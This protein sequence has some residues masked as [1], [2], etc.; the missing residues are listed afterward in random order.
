MTLS[1]HLP[2]LWVT[3]TLGDVLTRSVER[4]D[5]HRRPD[6]H[7]FYLG[8]EHV[9]SNSGHLVDAK[10]VKG[11]TIQSAKTVFH[12]N[13]ILYGKLRP[14][15]NK[16][17]LA[18]RDGIA[19]TD[20]WVLEPSPAV[21]PTYAASYLRSGFVLSRATQL[22]TGANLPR[23]H[24]E[25]FDAIPIPLPPLPEQQRIAVILHEVEA[26]T[27][28]RAHANALLE[29]L[30]AAVF[31]GMFGSGAASARHPSRVKMG[32]LLAAPLSHGF[33]PSET[34]SRT[35]VP[36]FTLDAITDHGIAH[37]AVKF[38]AFQDY[39]GNG[40]DLEVDDILITRSN[41]I[42]LVGKAARY[43]G[44]PSPVIYPDLTIRIRLKDPTDSPYVE[45]YLRSP[46]MRAVIRRLARGTSG[47][48]KKISQGDIEQ[49]DILWPD[50]Q[51][52]DTFARR[53]LAVRL[54]LERSRYG[55]TLL[56]SLLRALQAQA[57]TGQL[58][59]SW[60]N[61]HDAELR[62]A[63]VQRDV[64]LG[65]Q[66][67]EARLAHELEQDTLREEEAT[68]SRLLELLMPVAQQIQV[69]EAEAHRALNTAAQGEAE[70]AI[71]EASAAAARTAAERLL[72]A[73]RTN[74]F[75]EVTSILERATDAQRSVL[76][77]RLFSRLRESSQRIREALASSRPWLLRTE[78][79]LHP[80]VDSGNPDV[81]SLLS[82]LDFVK[83]AAEIASS[84]SRDHLLDAMTEQQRRIYAATIDATDYFAPDDI[85]VRIE[86]SDD[87][88]DVPP[89]SHVRSTL[90][91]LAATGLL[92][93]VASD[94]RTAEDNTTYTT[95][96]RR[97]QLDDETKTTDFPSSPEATT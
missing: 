61:K 39:A 79:A 83:S 1:L 3:S 74:D 56:E 42:D 70:S 25:A 19:S 41:T 66:R 96:Y 82:T 88:S 90:E 48:M 64:V 26:L 71:A 62:D 92:M 4:L 14:Y 54:L 45:N 52:R 73:L 33:S 32:D 37:T 24:P 7:F 50:K 85:Q 57:F 40:S 10:V 58:T 12:S 6:E 38:S 87:A 29:K 21:D 46:Y 44:K 59:A 13:N 72:L 67:T 30:Y 15:L 78:E 35:G 28:L 43:A 9:E 97:L 81:K 80:E 89:I 16:V 65:L 94:A 2:P 84:L 55:S 60:R 86:A 23:L 69:A 11:T 93:A 5:P 91:L 68:T 8:L 47:S 53:A 34:G 63:A 27:L 31:Q 49:F 22:A 51:E 20:F 75:S 77:P 36:V 17:H 95:R 76:K 18:E